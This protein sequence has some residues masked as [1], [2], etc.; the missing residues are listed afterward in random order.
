MGACIWSKLSPTQQ[1]RVLTA[2]QRSMAGGAAALDKLGVQLKADAAQCARRT[3]L[4]A[5]W[6]P[7]LAGAEAVQVYASTALKTP[8]SKLDAA[9]A[10]APAKVATCVRANGRLAFYPNGLGC[11]DP[12][13]SAWLLKQ[14][15]FGSSQPPAAQLAAYYFN[16]KA[17]GEWGDQLAA[18]LPP[19][20]R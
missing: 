13:A 6:P 3:D 11:T 19:N 2:Y 8:R 9:W 4:P 1:T 16:A 14:V 15:G 20:G 5:D 7:T 12:T 18:K 17:I 10:A